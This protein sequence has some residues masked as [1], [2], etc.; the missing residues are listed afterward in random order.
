[1]R[2]DPHNH[3]AVSNNEGGGSGGGVRGVAILINILTNNRKLSVNRN[4][5]KNFLKAQSSSCLAKQ[6]LKNW[7][8][9][10]NLNSSNP[11]DRYAQPLV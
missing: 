8:I 10:K 6:I 11:I 9:E 3:L 1:M 2:L 5:V 4:N 7:F